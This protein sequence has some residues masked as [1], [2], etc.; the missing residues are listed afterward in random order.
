MVR[1]NK[2]TC[3]TLALS[4]LLSNSFSFA[5]AEGV[6]AKAINAT[7]SAVLPDDNTTKIQKEIKESIDEQFEN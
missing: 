5:L 6:A 2:I 1:L 4:I 3:A 7:K